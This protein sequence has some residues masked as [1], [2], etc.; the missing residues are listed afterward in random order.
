MTAFRTTKA[1]VM[2]SRAKNLEKKKFSVCVPV[3]EGGWVDTFFTHRVFYQ[4]T[5]TKTLHMKKVIQPVKNHG[6]SILSS[7][8]PYIIN[9]DYE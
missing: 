8:K 7:E 3:W 1:L 6:N 9:F 4:E 2:L 5:V